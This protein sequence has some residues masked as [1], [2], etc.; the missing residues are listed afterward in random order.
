M[1]KCCWPTA[2]GCRRIDLYAAYG[3]PADEANAHRVSRAGP[4]PRRRHAG[5]LSRRPPRV[6]L[7]RLRSDA[8]RADSAAGDGASRRRAAGSCEDSE[9]ASPQTPA[10]SPSPIDIADVGTGSGILAV[11][12]AKYVPNSR[13]TAIDISPAALA[14]AR[15][16]AER[17]GVAERIE[18]VESDLFATVP[19][20]PRFD[21]IVS[22]PPYVSTAEMAE[23]AAGRARARAARRTCMPANAG[24]TSSRRSS[25]K[26]PQRLKPGGALFIEISPMIA[27][28]VEQLIRD[29]RGVRTWSDAPRPGRPPARRAGQCS[30]HTP[31]A[32]AELTSRIAKSCDCMH[33]P[34]ATA[35][36]CLH[37]RRGRPAEPAALRFDVIGPVGRIFLERA[38]HHVAAWR[39]GRRRSGR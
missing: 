28:E 9:L 20:E 2:R 36:S 37:V 34:G 33:R 24:P 7:A 17:H 3:E 11:C 38:D 5:R 35:T 22:N 4:P 39:R 31:R 32:V 27:A 1:R 14:V 18:F 15:R 8:G 6:L 19:A 12:A 10:P 21:Y 29:T 13:V 23:L 30:R 25:S 26:R 16:N